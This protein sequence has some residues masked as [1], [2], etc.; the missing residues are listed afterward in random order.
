MPLPPIVVDRMVVVLT[1][2]AQAEL[3]EANTVSFFSVALGLLDLADETR[4]HGLP[5][6]GSDALSTCCEISSRQ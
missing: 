1:P 2:E 6:V 5:P 3:G 4:V